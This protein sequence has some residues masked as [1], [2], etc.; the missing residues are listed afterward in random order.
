MAGLSLSST[1]S[2]STPA[3][4][5]EDSMDTLLYFGKLSTINL[6]DQMI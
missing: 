2:K 1:N 5:K 4:M 6:S 3:Y